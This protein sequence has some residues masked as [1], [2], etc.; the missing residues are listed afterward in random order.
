MEA[1]YKRIESGRNASMI[2]NPAQ[3]ANANFCIHLIAISGPHRS[4]QVR[5]L[6]VAT[7]ETHAVYE[8]QGSWTRC[9]R[10]IQK[11]P[12]GSISKQDLAAAKRE[13]GRDRYAAFPTITASLVELESIGL[14]RVD[15]E[16]HA[17]SIARTRIAD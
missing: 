3:A 10:W 16:Q 13:F 6:F 12:C 1:Q 2:E 9:V 15:Q 14:Q 7:T 5:M 11:L 17:P 4:P 8:G